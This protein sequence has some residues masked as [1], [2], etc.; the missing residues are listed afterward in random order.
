MGT[1]IHTV[2]FSTADYQRFSQR[3]EANLQRLEALLG[4]PG[5]GEGPASLGAELELY[6]VDGAG[7]PA[8]LNEE[9]QAATSS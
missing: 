6:V 7:R 8:H 2:Q 1:D 3:L 5:F 4:V 9:L